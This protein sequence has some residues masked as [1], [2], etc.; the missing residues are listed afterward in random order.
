MRSLWT[1]GQMNVNYERWDDQPSVKERREVI[2]K[3]EK[4]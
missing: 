2:K 3:K 1:F 4:A